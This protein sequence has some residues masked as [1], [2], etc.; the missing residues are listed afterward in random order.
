[1]DYESE[2]VLSPAM[3]SAAQAIQALTDVL[4]SIIEAKISRHGELTVAKAILAGEPAKMVIFDVN[5]PDFAIAVR[6]QQNLKRLAAAMSQKPVKPK[7]PAEPGKKATEKQKEEY[8]M[9]MQKYQEEMARY[10]VQ[11][12]VGQIPY[13]L[14]NVSNGKVAITVRERDMERLDRLCSE[15]VC[16]PLKSIDLALP[17]KEKEEG[18]SEEKTEGK[19]EGK[20]D[21]KTTRDEKKM[22][23]N[24]KREAKR[25]KR[26]AKTEER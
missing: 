23:R 21:K 12:E 14:V 1:M 20:S 24:A 15:V 18:R 17:E 16:I 10:N 26:E 11:K 4:Q 8:E 2:D 5:N 19:S 22:K 25:A 13:T 9:Q 3:Q 7:E 6:Q